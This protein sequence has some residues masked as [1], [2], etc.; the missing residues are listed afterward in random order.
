MIELSESKVQ[1]QKEEI[2]SVLN[3]ETR[4]SLNKT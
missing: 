3:N 1:H 2:V 4:G